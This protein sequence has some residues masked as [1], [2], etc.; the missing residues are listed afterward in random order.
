MIERMDVQP[1]APSELPFLTAVDVIAASK[2]TLV[3]G[4]GQLHRRRFAEYRFLPSG[5][6]TAAAWQCAVSVLGREHC[7]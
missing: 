3:A 6:I 7:R 4:G 5:V 1:N 2:L